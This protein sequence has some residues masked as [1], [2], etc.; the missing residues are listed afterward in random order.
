ME[1]TDIRPRVFVSSVIEGFEAYREAARQ[2]IEAA[3]GEPILVNEDFPSQA[4]SSRNV[5]LDAVDSADIYIAVLGERGGWTAPSGRLVVE[6]EYRRARVNNL[7]V[8][9]FLQRVERDQDAER[10][11]RLFSDYVEGRFRVAFETP[12]QLAREVRRALQPILETFSLPPMNRTL[13]QQEVESPFRMA[14]DPSLRFA[15]APIRRKEVVDPVTLE[16]NAFRE[17]IYALAHPPTGRLLQYEKPTRAE[18]EGAALVI[19]Q[20]ASSSTRGADEVRLEIRESGQLVI[21]INLTA[22]MQQRRARGLTGL[23]VSEEEIE[24]ALAHCFGFAASF[25]E[26]RDPYSRHQQFAYNAAANLGHRALVPRHPPSG[27]S[28]Q[29]PFARHSSSTAAYDTPRE[30]GRAVLQDPSEEIPRL[31]AL[32]RRKSAS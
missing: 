8:L 22:R 24:A 15:L 16:S 5:C 13:L 20:G 17:E 19:Y 18:I 9:V 21:D 6:E 3:G 1:S 31:I 32:F 12:E 7:P 30:I 26:H 14:N 25:Y 23:T 27:A 11:A 10:L 2:G 28:V 4:D 29:V